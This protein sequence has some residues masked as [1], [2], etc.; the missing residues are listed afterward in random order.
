MGR[1]ALFRCDAAL[2]A[3]KPCDWDM[4]TDWGIAGIKGLL[5]RM[6]SRCRP[7]VQF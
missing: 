1:Q 3:G 4:G 6:E 2:A 5:G 7:F